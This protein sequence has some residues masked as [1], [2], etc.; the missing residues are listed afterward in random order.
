MYG[1]TVLMT[2]VADNGLLAEAIF[3]QTA[4]TDD[5]AGKVV[6]RDALP[7]QT[8]MLDTFENFSQL[9]V[10]ANILGRGA[11]TTCVTLADG[12]V[13]LSRAWLEQQASSVGSEGDQMLA[14][15]EDSRIL[16]I[17]P[18]K[19]AGLKIR[20]QEVT[21]ESQTPVLVHQDEDIA[22]TYE[23]ELE[24]IIWLVSQ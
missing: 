2:D 9:C 15:S 23:V 8:V 12:N 10:G 11:F 17:D 14:P 4:V 22:V 20:V 7:I 21:K 13:R 16:W 3:R 24:G 6:S 1:R 18:D 5:N 19:T